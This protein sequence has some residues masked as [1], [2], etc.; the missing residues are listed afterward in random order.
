MTFSFIK[1]WEFT[2]QPPLIPGIC[3]AS[4]LRFA[5]LQ[6]AK[7]AHEGPPPSETAHFAAQI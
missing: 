5:D 3:L 2:P 1:L 6:T 7:H 4:N